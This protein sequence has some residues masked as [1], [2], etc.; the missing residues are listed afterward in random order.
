MIS[1]TFSSGLATVLQRYVGMKR[2]LGRQFDSATHAL[3]SMDGLLTKEGYPDLNGSAFDAWCRTQEHMASGVRRVRLRC[4]PSASIGVEQS[5]SA[6][7]QIPP[8]FRHII[9]GSGRTSSPNRRLR[10]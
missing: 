1:P 6:S 8:H 7:Y 10:G 4:M 3:Q 2:A 5:P 9:S